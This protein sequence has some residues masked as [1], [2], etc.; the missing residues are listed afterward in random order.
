MIMLWPAWFSSRSSSPISSPVAVSSAP[1]GSSA[2]SSS[3]ELTSA[4]SDRYSLPLTAGEPGRVR[5]PV[6]ADLQPVEQLARAAPG[7]CPGQPCQLRRQQHVVG[8][9][10]VVEQVE[11]LE[12]HSDALPPV[13]RE[14]RLAHRVDPLACHRHGPRR[15][16]VESGDQVEQRRLAAAGRPHDCHGLAGRDLEADVLHRERPV[17]VVLLADSR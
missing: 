16:P 13:F 8:H 5:L 10:Q 1:V 11:E 14:A 6:L 9:G 12:N 15:R 17:L 7:S 4:L 2:S 3:G